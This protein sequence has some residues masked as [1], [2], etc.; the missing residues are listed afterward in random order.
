MTRT[1]QIGEVEEDDGASE[2]PQP[3]DVLPAGA[4]DVRLL[5]EANVRAMQA[6]FQHNQRTLEIG[7]RMTDSLRDGVRVLAEAPR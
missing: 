6:A 5:L 2:E 1:V 4:T 3:L 7:L